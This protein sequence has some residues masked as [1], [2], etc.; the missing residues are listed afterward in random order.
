MTTT[1]LQYW[2][3]LAIRTESHVE[4]LNGQE[5]QLIQALELVSIAGEI[6]DQVKRKIYYGEKGEY[7]FEKLNA[8]ADR[9]AQLDA[10]DFTADEFVN[11]APATPIED[12]NTR[13]VHGIIGNITEAAELGEALIEYLRTGKFDVVNLM[14]E[15]ADIDWYQAVL[16]DELH[17]P[18]EASYQFL[19][20]KLAARYGDAFTDEAATIRD[21]GT[22]RE[23]MERFLKAHTE[24]L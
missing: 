19:V 13:V 12:P 6:L 21:L 20:A 2:A 24:S 22:E 16:A 10:F 4:T 3:D 1:N 8:A 14:E 23:V 9:L 17:F 7:K 18:A 15:K 5:A 11:Q